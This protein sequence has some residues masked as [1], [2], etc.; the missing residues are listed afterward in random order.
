[1]RQLVV[2]VFVLSL[3]WFFTTTSK[4]RK[5]MTLE[6]SSTVHCHW[7]VV[8]REHNIVH[9]LPLPFL[10]PSSPSPSPFHSLPLLL[11]PL[12]L[13][14]SLLSLSLPLFVTPSPSLSLF[15][16]LTIFPSLYILPPALFFLLISFYLLTLPLQPSFPSILTLS[17]S[18]LMQIQIYIFLLPLL[19]RDST[20]NL[21]FFFRKILS[22]V[23]LFILHLYF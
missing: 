2:L 14:S 7:K 20:P 1:M 18:Y 6:E 9:T 13:P 11:L 12:L 4:Q 23:R 10:L 3:H 5:L 16:S 19:V 21:V 8:G 22:R 17:L 15:F